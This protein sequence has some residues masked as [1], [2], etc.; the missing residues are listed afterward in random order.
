MYTTTQAIQFMKWKASMLDEP[1]FASD[2]TI[3]F[4]QQNPDIAEKLVNNTRNLAEQY[5]TTICP[6]C[7][8]YVTDAFHCHKCEFGKEFGYCL[9]ENSLYQR[10]KDRLKEDYAYDSITDYLEDHVED[11]DYAINT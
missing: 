7:I 10:V 11:T 9:I 2:I 3:T 4:L 8:K 6:F 5:D 1:A